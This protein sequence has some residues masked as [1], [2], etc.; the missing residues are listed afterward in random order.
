M[1]LKFQYEL[2]RAYVTAGLLRLREERAAEE[3]DRGDVPQ[4]VIV[5][6]IGAALA[7]AI[8]AIIVK[9]VTDKT[10]TITLQ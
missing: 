1:D 5:T 7:I 10:N 4:W 6:A 2:L 8:G 3:P 9:K